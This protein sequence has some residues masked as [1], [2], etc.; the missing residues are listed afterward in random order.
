MS[1]SWRSSQHLHQAAGIHAPI[2]TW[3]ERKTWTWCWPLHSHT[4][5]MAEL[6]CEALFLSEFSALLVSQL[7]EFGFI[8]VVFKGYRVGVLFNIVFFLNV[9][10]FSL[11]RSKMCTWLGHMAGIPALWRRRQVIIAHLEPASFIWSIPGQ[12]GL[13][14]KTQSQK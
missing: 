12:P 6:S 13:H 14:S 4:V 8:V 10:F 2:S 1:S 9:F 3:M 11:T 5:R 7:L